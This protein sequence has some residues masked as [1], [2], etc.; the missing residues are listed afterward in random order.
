MA[1][2]FTFINC[3]TILIKCF[4]NAHFFFLKRTSVWNSVFDIMRDV[5][6]KGIKNNNNNKMNDNNQNSKLK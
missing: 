2:V 6:I 5:I 4:E 1:C 3:T